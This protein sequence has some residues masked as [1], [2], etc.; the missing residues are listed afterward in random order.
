[1]S[2]RLACQSLMQYMANEAGKM[3]AGNTVDATDHG[4]VFDRTSQ[5]LFVYVKIPLKAHTRPD[6]F[7]LRE[8]ELARLMQEAQAGDVI[9]WGQSL[10]D[11]DQGALQRP[12]YQRIDIITADLA[13]ARATLRTMLEMLVVP[14]GTEIHY[15]QAGRMMMDVYARG[16]WQLDQA[17]A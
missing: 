6:P 15:S 9:G 13:V 11:I 8:N 7:H 4:T 12:V 17:S 16:H 3:G 10:G 14:S 2:T 5:T 1:M